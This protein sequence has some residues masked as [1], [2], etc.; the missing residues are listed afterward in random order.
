MNHIERKSNSGFPSGTYLLD[1]DRYAYNQFLRLLDQDEASPFY[2]S[3]LFV[4]GNDIK[5]TLDEHFKEG[6]PRYW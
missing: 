6:S 1:Y 5:A 3:G 2:S 4:Y